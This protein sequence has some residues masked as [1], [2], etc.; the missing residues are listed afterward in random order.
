MHSRAIGDPATSGECSNT[1]VLNPTSPYSPRTDRVIVF[2]A[3]AVWFFGAYAVGARWAPW[4]DETRFLGIVRDF[5][6]QL[7]LD[8]LRTYPAMTTPLSFLLYAAWGR[9]AGF[10]AWQ[11]RLLSPFLAVVTFALFDEVLRRYDVTRPAR[12]FAIAV[13]CAN[14]YVIGL[15]VFVFTDMPA[16]LMVVLVLAA[17]RAE[18]PWWAAAGVAGG[19]L[20]RQYDAFLALA[21]LLAAIGAW[22]HGRRQFSIALIG[23]AIV[24]VAPFA[25]LVWLW[26]GLAPA[27][28][29]R[30]ELLAAGLHFN[31]HW[32]SLYLAAPGIYLAPLVV[33]SLSRR[34][35]RRLA[36]VCGAAAA[37]FTMAF[38][39]Q[40]SAVQIAECCGDTGYAHRMLLLVPV[41]FFAPIVFAVAAF[42]WMAVMANVLVQSID[43]WRATTASIGGVF[44]WLALVSFLLVMPWS[45]M[46]WEKYALPELLFATVILVSHVPQG[47][48][49]GLRGVVR[50]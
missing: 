42:G 9:L 19:M 13:L 17:M 14:P 30:A 21:I 49:A 23:A 29:L 40:P 1:T 20:T 31:P 43:G 38:P 33:W 47:V 36:I 4:G 32:L 2:A 26:H 22:R 6:T 5:G 24:G 12:L 11:L 41:P 48:R 10:E 3:L 28:D 37:L 50:S 34:R 44:P 18:R 15:S 25:M 45:Y 8:A 7:N 35:P 39:I 16:L 46:P 27:N